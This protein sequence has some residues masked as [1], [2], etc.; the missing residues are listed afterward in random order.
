MRGRARIVAD[1]VVAAFP[2]TVPRMNKS[3]RVVALITLISGVAYLMRTD[4]AVAQERMVPALGLTMA[5]MGAITAWGFQLTYALLQVPAGL[6]GER[7][8]VRMAL[9]LAILGCAV[10][11]LAT[12]WMPATGA[13]GTLVATRVLLGASQAAIFPVAALAVSQ[14]VASEHRLRANALYIASAS[15]GAAIAPVLMAPVMERFGWRAVFLVSGIIGALTMVTCFTMLPRPNAGQ[16]ASV[17]RT[18]V[19]VQLRDARRLLLM[20]NLQRLSLAYLLHSA[21]YFVFVFWF[22]RYLTEGRGFTVLAS[23]VWA[24]L[25][26]VAGFVAAPLIGALADQVGRRIGGG[27]ARRRVAMGCLLSATALSLVGALVPGAVFAIVAL[28]LSSASV[29]GAESPFFT[30][31]TVIGA[32]NPGGAAGVL[33]LMGNLGGVLSIWLV[34]IMSAA[35]GWNGTIIF[36]SAVACS[37][38]LL[39]L[40][41]RAPDDA[42][43]AGA[44]SP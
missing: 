11:S 33:N 36:W 4:I 1:P 40:T 31:A 24:A 27:R 5:G 6:F 15:L 17:A 23:G 39:W 32:T 14:Y 10:A 21:V 44:T 35:W 37:A 38:A 13:V 20:P 7:F 29:N 30:T 43:P 26:N 12:A 3:W 19:A 22:F 16:A 9:G 8:G 25:P 2:P 28:S 41:V 34:P 18:T 42:P